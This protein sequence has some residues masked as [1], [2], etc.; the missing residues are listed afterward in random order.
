MLREHNLDD[1]S[2]AASE[3]SRQSQSPDGRARVRKVQ[4]DIAGGLG[5]H[6]QDD[7]E[8]EL[9]LGQTQNENLSQ[10]L[11]ELEQDNGRVNTPTQRSS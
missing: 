11:Q 6:G 5:G 10:G 4:R 7:S 1:T 8:D 9:G 3:R 2:P